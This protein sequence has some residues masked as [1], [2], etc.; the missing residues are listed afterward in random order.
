MNQTIHRDLIDRFGEVRKQKLH[1]MCDFIENEIS[2]PSTMPEEHFAAIVTMLKG[3]DEK[4]FTQVYE[5]L[6]FTTNQI[7]NWVIC[8][9]AFT[10]SDEPAIHI[11]KA[12]LGELRRKIGVRATP[13]TV[14]TKPQEEVVS[15][16]E[17]TPALEE[18]PEGIMLSEKF[19]ADVVLDDIPEWTLGLSRR[20]RNG[21]KNDNRKCMIDVLKMSAKEFFKIGN[22]SKKSFDE[23]VTWCHKHNMRGVFFDHPRAVAVVKRLE[24]M[25]KTSGSVEA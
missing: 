1:E 4:S 14:A 6:G 11:A 10:P 13:S 18:I 24:D 19:P 23:L 15:E 5:K 21:L 2:S 20:V 3:V 9:M 25:K 8:H 22:V 7:N 16:V 12:L 17:P